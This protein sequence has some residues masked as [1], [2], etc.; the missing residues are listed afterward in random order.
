MEFSVVQVIMLCSSSTSRALV[1][2]DTAGSSPALEELLSLHAKKVM[3]TKAYK[4][5]NLNDNER[6][7]ISYNN[8]KK[9]GIAKEAMPG[10]FSMWMNKD[11][12]RCS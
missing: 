3:V 2:V 11:F 6:I 1:F 9:N 10:R 5:N 7:V 8:V 12:A 4:K